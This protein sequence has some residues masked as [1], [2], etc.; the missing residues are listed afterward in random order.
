MS[1]DYHVYLGPYLV[2][3]KKKVIKEIRL[4]GC[5]N[6]RCPRYQKNFLG[7][8]IGKFCRECGVAIG[9]FS[10]ERSVEE[11]DWY[12]VLGGD[13]KLARAGGEAESRGGAVFFLVPNQR[14]YPSC[15]RVD[16]REGDCQENISPF[17]I[18]GELTRFLQDFDPEIRKC[19]EA[20][21]K[22]DAAWG[23]LV[24]SS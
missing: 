5:V 7:D 19:R 11:A 18:D 17:R 10:V 9:T 24:W 1:T 4:R 16:P 8:S 3:P 12:E 22:A 14:S 2:C 15:L 13:A 23:L 21:G 6:P 20:F